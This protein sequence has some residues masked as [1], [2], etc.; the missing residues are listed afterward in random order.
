MTTKILGAIIVL[1][2]A[3]SGIYLLFEKS[4]TIRSISSFEEC[5]AAGYPVMES[6]PRQCRAEETT[7]TEKI[8]ESTGKENLIRVSSPGPNVTITSPVTIIGEARG[9]W[10][11]EASFPV[12]ILDA[13]GKR[14]AMAP[15]QANG[16]WMTENFVPFEAKVTFETPTTPTGTIIFHKDNPSGLPEND[17]KLEIPVRFS[18]ASASTTTRSVKIY[19]YNEANDKDSKGNILCSSKGLVQTS[20]TIPFTATPIQDTLK[21]LFA[22]DTNFRG[23]ELKGATLKNGTLTIELSDPQ[24]S[25]TGGSC[26]VGILRAQ[27]EATVKQFDGIQTVTFIPA[28][29]LQ[30]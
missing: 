1:L 19:L 21:T 4:P 26:K 17:D 28:E 3:V 10:Y 18:T 16:E 13:N 22:A 20:K 23:V 27:I 25:T 24:K 8:S 29:V 9:Y 12:E 2:L 5:V 15:I 7:F 30:P 14:L 11:F 6:Y